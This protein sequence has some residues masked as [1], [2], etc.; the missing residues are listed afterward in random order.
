[1]ATDISFSG[2]LSYMLEDG[3]TFIRLS[4][5]VVSGVGYDLYDFNYS[6]G[7]ALTEEFFQWPA[8][9]QAGYGTLGT[10]GHVFESYFQVNSGRGDIA[11]EV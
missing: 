6:D 5:V 9:V 1:M 7:S 10:A 2:K 4:D 11:V 8:M 3:S